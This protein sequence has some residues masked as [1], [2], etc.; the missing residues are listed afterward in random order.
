MKKFSIFTLVLLA[1]VLSACNF[2]GFEET[3]VPEQSDDAMATEISKILTGT[4]VEIQPSAT[5]PV[6]EEEPTQPVETEETQPPATATPEPEEEEEEEA[7]PTPEPT[8]TPT[9]EPT[10]TQVADTDPVLTLGDPDWVDNMANGDNWATGYSDYTSIKFEDSFLKL[11]AESDIDGWRLSWPYLEDFYLEAKLQTPECEGSDHFGLM[12]RVPE[13]SNANKGYL[14]GITCDGKFSLR[15]W[16]G[17]TMY[18]PVGATASDEIN[19]GEDVVNT[20]GVMAD[21]AKLSLYINGV[22]VKELT[23]DAYLAGTFGFFVGS[24]NVE[25]LEVWVDQIRYWELD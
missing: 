9:A 12:F 4:P 23:D 19:A 17:Q 24:D 2:P 18:F 14:F 11:K 21:G 3:A 13:N 7:T 1:L 6:E 5:M 20:L 15:R 25:D 10:E 8:E 22:K 16:D